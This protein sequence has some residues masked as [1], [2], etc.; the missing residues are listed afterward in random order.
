MALNYLIGDLKGDEVKICFSDGVGVK[1]EVDELEKLLFWEQQFPIGDLFPS[2]EK[3]NDLVGNRFKTFNEI[4]EQ[5]DIEILNFKN[6]NLDGAQYLKSTW[7]VDL[8][9][10]VRYGVILKEEFISCPKIGILNL[11]SGILP[12]YRGIMSTFWAMLNGEKQIGATLHKITD[13]EIDSGEIL[14]ISKRDVCKN[15]S[16][17]YNIA[18][19][20]EQGCKD[21][22]T[23]V[24][25]VRKSGK[26]DVNFKDK[27]TEASIYNS[28]PTKSDFEDFKKKFKVSDK[29]EFFEEIITLYLN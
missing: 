1:K 12:K 23:A 10:S 14:A 4:S 19:L 20:Y 16:L 3:E 2:L 21:I 22:I 5:N 11:H 15:K 24:N 9:I 6:I 7:S 18:S 8:V 17:I 29:K 26:I 28:Y 27:N 25:D 13:S